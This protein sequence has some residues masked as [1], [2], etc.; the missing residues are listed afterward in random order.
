MFASPLAKMAQS[1]LIAMANRMVRRI[2]PNNAVS[3]AAGQA[4][5]VFGL[6]HG[7]AAP[8]KMLQGVIERAKLY[9][10]ALSADEVAGA[11][12]AA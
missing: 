5:V 10:R 6:R 2:A 3:F 12:D 11:R 4:Q 9:D 7:P 8:G 1:R